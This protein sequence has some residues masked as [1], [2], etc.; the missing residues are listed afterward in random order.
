LLE[1]YVTSR[2]GYRDLQHAGT[3]TE[4]AVTSTGNE[5]ENA[6]GHNVVFSFS[7][8]AGFKSSLIAMRLMP[9]GFLLDI[10]PFALFLCLFVLHIWGCL[11][12]WLLILLWDVK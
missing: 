5:L 7:S 8:R 10:S 6:R 4:N 3:D 11:D 1:V 12:R 9:V 2:S